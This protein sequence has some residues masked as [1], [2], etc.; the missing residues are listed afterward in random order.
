VVSRFVYGSMRHVPDYLEKGGVTY[1][2]VSDNLGSVRRVVNAATGEVVQRMDYDAWGRVTL[3]T[4]P[5]FQPFGFAG[6]IYEGSTALVRF[7][8]RDYDAHTGRWT[9]KDP[10]GFAGLDANLYGYVVRDPVNLVDTDGRIPAPVVIAGLIG[11]GFN[12]W[13][14]F[15]DPCASWADVAQDFAAGFVGGAVGGA[16]GRLGL[17]LASKTL[18]GAMGG[19]YDRIITSHLSGNGSP[20]LMPD[21]TAGAATGAVLNSW[22]LVNHSE[23]IKAVVD[24]VTAGLIDKAISGGK[25][26][27]ASCEC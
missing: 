26:G 7:G 11:G 16:V 5:G 27:D 9:S 1:R 14:S 8:A 4:N 2:I 6:G 22:T 24:G 15:R 23:S 20:E 12:A 13:S 21:L 3:D 25:T 10:I 19:A 17:Q 18:A